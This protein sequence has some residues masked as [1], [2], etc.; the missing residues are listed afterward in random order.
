[1]LEKS[2][3]PEAVIER[4]FLARRDVAQRSD[5]QPAFP[6]VPNRFAV[7]FAGMIHEARGISLRCIRRVDTKI[8]VDFE[9][10]N[11]SFR[12][13]AGTRLGAAFRFLARNPLSAIFA[14]ERSRR[15]FFRRKDAVPVHG[16]TPHFDFRETIH[17]VLPESSARSRNVSA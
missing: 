8:F 9:N 1:M 5:F 4:Q 14:N 7:F 17:A 16:R 2:D 11:R 3:K 10:K 15:N 13:F 6:R 12:I